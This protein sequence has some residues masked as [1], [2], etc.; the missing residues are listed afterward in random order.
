[1][2]VTVDRSGDAFVGQ[3][4]SLITKCPSK[5]ASAPAGPTASSRGSDVASLTIGRACLYLG[6]AIALVG[7]APRSTERSVLPTG[8]R[9]AAARCSRSPGR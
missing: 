9:S 3:K 2:I 5:F 6:L 1:M 7:S 4:D 8:S